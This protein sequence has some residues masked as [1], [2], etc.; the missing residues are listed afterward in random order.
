MLVVS[1]MAGATTLVWSLCARCGCG[2][3]AHMPRSWPGSLLARLGDDSP[4]WGSCWTTEPVELAHCLFSLFR[5]D[6]RSLATKSHQLRSE[7]SGV[8]RPPCP[9]AQESWGV[10][11]A[12]L[13]RLLGV[14]LQ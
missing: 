13:L 10:Q 14:G 8:T 7:E 5:H 2:F 1:C 9:G 6:S 12:K 3:W 4:P 11:P